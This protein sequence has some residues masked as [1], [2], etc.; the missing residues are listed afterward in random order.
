MNIDAAKWNAD[1]DVIP[2]L[3]GW[4]NVARAQTLE[5]TAFLAGAAINHL[6]QILNH[7][8]V[9][10]DLLRDRLALRAAEACVTHSGRPERRGQLRDI[11][12][13]LRPGD[14]PGPAGD[15]YLNWRRAVERPISKPAMER[16]LPQVSAAQIDACFAEK[17]G[18]A[19]TTAARV[20]EAVLAD[21]PRDDAGALIL[22]DAVM[23]RTLGWRDLVPIFAIGLSRPDLRK[24]DHELAYA[25]HR[26]VIKA[27]REA[28]R[29]ASDVT[30]R[31]EQLRAVAPKLRA[32]GAQDAVQM[33]LS[34]DALAPSALPLA[35]RAARRLCDRLVSLGVIRELT[36]RKTFRLYG[37]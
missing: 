30:R 25:C 10:V 28:T 18:A 29:L 20:I 8:A 33:F 27:V 31:A 6:Q 16:A 11:L 24:S 5:D 19:V 22:A 21:S 7:R 36:G 14:L 35:D 32:S 17:S 15:I 37:V 9:P 13:M 3:P 12:H 26:A 4:V 34:R 1:P 23:A 2:N